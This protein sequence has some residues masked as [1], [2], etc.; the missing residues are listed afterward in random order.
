[1]KYYQQLL[2]ITMAVAVLWSAEPVGREIHGSHQHDASSMAAA[3]VEHVIWDGN[4][5]ST[6]HGNLHC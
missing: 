3:S 1:M 2:I 6:I 5:I 4:Q